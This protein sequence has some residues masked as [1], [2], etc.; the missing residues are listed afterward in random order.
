MVV[1]PGEGVAH[2][3]MFVGTAGRSADD[4]FGQADKGGDQVEDL[5]DLELAGEQ[6]IPVRAELLGLVDQGVK[7]GI[8]VTHGTSFHG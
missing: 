4:R 6:G 5:L 3:L 1:E 7:V 8:G 2:E